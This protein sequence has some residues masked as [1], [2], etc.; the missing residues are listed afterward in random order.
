[1]VV[2]PAG[3]RTLGRMFPD[4]KG[5]ISALGTSSAASADSEPYVGPCAALAF[6]GSSSAGL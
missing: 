3:G 4:P 5:H 1:L 6:C 2:G